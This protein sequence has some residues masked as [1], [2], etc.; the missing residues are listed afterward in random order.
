MS[1]PAVSFVV[2][3]YDEAPSLPVLHAE[4][5]AAAAAQGMDFEVL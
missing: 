2:P 1:R 3:L 5:V 4:I